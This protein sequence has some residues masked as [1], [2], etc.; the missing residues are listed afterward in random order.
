MNY[1]NDIERLGAAVEDGMDRGDA[2]RE[3]RDLLE[4]Q[5][6]GR[7]Y[8]DYWSTGDLIDDW[9]NVRRRYEAIRD[10][11]GRELRMLGGMARFEEEQQRENAQ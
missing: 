3:L 8:A 1:L 9:R 10:I 2:I 4:Q 5:H 6:F 11:S 7:E